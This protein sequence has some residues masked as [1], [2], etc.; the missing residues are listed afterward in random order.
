M[1]SLAALAGCPAD[2]TSEPLPHTSKTM[3]HL[4]L[5]VH[6]RERLFARGKELVVPPS[7]CP[8]KSLG[9]GTLLY[10]WGQHTAIFLQEM[11]VYG[12][13]PAGQISSAW[14]SYV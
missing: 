5:P 12:C 9:M 1:V 2:L 6:T 10:A 11:D 13:P 7:P 8:A 4:C 14:L 3:S